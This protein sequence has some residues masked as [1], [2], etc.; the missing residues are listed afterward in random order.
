M[1]TNIIVRDIDAA[2]HKALKIKAVEQGK[3]L[4]DLIKEILAQYIRARGQK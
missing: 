2:L 3:S 1:A 4:Q